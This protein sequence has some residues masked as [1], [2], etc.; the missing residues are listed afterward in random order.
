MTI[1]LDDP[2]D[3]IGV[4]VVVDG[5]LGQLVPLVGRPAVDGKT[6]LAVLVFGFAQ[7]GHHLLKI[8]ISNLTILSR[9]T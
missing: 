7:I 1:Y 4:D 2:A 8:I 6:E 9:R 5:P 3:V